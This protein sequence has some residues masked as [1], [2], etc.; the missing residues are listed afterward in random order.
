[1][2]GSND[3]FV[4]TP[5]VM[6]ETKKQNGAGA[7]AGARWEQQQQCLMSHMTHR[8]ILY[9]SLAKTGLKFT[10]FVGREISR[11]VEIQIHLFEIHPKFTPKNFV[12]IGP[13]RTFLLYLMYR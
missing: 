4:S 5:I 1:M 13:Y 7:G 10:F 8:S 12:N 3:R 11:P 2:A 9:I 6:V